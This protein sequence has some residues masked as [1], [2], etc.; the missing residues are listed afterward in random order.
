MNWKVVD[1]FRENN[2]SLIKQCSISIL[3]S[4][5]LIYFFEKMSYID[6]K[7]VWI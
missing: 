2:L 5:G 7:R 3:T 6:E 4:P 1:I